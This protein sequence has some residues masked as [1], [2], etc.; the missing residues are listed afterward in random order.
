M[1]QRLQRLRSKRGFT[2]IE[3]IVVIAII[4]V[5]VGTLLAGS[6]GRREKIIE[7]NST[8]SDFYATLQAEFTGL[9]MFDGPITMRLLNEVYAPVTGGPAAIPKNGNFGGLKY[10]PYAKGNYPCEEVPAGEDFR[11]AKPKTAHLYVKVYV[12]G[13]TLRRVNYANDLANILG[14]SGEGNAKSAELCLVLEQEMKERMQYNDGYYY[15]RVSY[16]APTGDPAG[17]SSGDY[18]SVS[19]RVD[20]AAYCPK[21]ITSA[22][23]SNTF[24]AQNVLKNGAVCGVHT[25]SG[26][27]ALGTT[28]TSF[29]DY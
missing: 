1:I 18:S 25:A 23:N 17:L 2:M 5:M 13:G 3:L 16:T 26:F 7:A 6:S 12:F 24:Q 8:A 10:Y 22:S 15:A 14:M 11:K 20:W 9:Q 4:A 21:E 29:V 28:G 27:T 19:V